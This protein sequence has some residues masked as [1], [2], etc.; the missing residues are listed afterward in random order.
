MQQNSTGMSLQG[1]SSQSEA[2]VEVN[3]N[4]MSAGG[5]VAARS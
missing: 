4:K 1:Q 3:Q 5:K 2:V